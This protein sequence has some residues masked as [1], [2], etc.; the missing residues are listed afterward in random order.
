MKEIKKI[1]QGLAS[2]KIVSADIVEVAPGKCLSVMKLSLA[3]GDHLQFI[4]SDEITQI[5]T[6]NIRSE[7]LPLMAKSP[8]VA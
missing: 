1:L 7:I 5:T 2:L 3:M 6:A 4:F 8:L